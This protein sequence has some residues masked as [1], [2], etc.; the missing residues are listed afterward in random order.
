[1]KGS[2][3]TEGSAIAATDRPP[4]RLRSSG[5]RPSVAAGH[6][7]PLAAPTRRLRRRSRSCSGWSRPRAGRV[8]RVRV[9]AAERAAP[10]PCAGSG[11]CLLRIGPGEATGRPRPA[12]LRDAGRRRPWGDRGG[13]SRVACAPFRVPRPDLPGPAGRAAAAPTPPAPPPA[14]PRGV[15]KGF[16]PAERGLFSGNQA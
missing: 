14:S 12:G 11:R 2:P 9:L 3:G 15:P 7:V 6:G 4:P 10:H 5:S 13:R 16:T 1:M 8:R